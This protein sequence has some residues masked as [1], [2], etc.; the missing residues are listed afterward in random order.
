MVTIQLTVQNKWNRE[1]QDVLPLNEKDFSIY[2]VVKFG[3]GKQA[4]AIYLVLGAWFFLPW[5]CWHELL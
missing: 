1:S 2:G 4:S 3:P 5:E